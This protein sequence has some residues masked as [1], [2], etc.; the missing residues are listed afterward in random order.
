MDYRLIAADLDGTLH[1]EEQPF[2]PRVRAAVGM[3]Q[4]R[5]VRVVMATGRVSRTALS[6]ARD[7]GLTSPVI[8]NHG[9]TIHEGQ[10]S[11]LLFQQTVP[12]ELA[13]E[14]IAWTPPDITVL[15]CAQEEFY[16]VRA[17]ED[18]IAFVGRYHNHMHIV[19]DLAQSLQLEPQ[20]IIFVNDEQVSTRLLGS[21][22]EQFG[23]R[24]HVVQSFSRYIEITHRDVS[25][26]SAVA[27]LAKRWGIL[28]EEVIAIGDQGNDI[29]MIEWAGLGVAMGNGVE[30]VKAIADYIAP[31]AEEDGVAHVIERFVLNA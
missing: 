30:S 8:C 4:E 17:S 23:H 1:A 24:L 16:V 6:F 3:A 2:T 27:W 20:K 13:R 19:P 21:L 9:A 10:T 28:R 31:S 11:A 14:V 26:A 5:G 7:L 22:R 12:L 29:S 15:V 25:K 18:A